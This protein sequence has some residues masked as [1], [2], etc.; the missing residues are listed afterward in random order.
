M[1]A[2][3]GLRLERQLVELNAHRVEGRKVLAVKPMTIPQALA[4][5]GLGMLIVFWGVAAWSVF[6]AG[7]QQAAGL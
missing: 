7:M 4:A 6:T 3:N 2:M 5:V 1:I